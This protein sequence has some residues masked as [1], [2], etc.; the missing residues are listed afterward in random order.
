MQVVQISVKKELKLCLEV[1]E[2]A[3]L[4]LDL[5]FFWDE[6]DRFKFQFHLKH[7]H[8][9]KYTNKGSTHNNTIFFSIKKGIFNQ[10][11]TNNSIMDHK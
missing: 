4:F 6:E 1:T 7:N 9:L 2:K 3:S 8:K 10:I 5:E 11:A